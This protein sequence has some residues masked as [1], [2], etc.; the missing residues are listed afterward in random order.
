MPPTG[1]LPAGEI[2]ALKTWIEQGAPWPAD[3]SAVSPLV[4]GKRTI[5]DKD[6][7]HWAFRPL[8]EPKPPKTSKRCL[9]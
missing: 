5:T 8:N 6:R 3:Q 2:A 7:Q 4:R 1:K 9:D